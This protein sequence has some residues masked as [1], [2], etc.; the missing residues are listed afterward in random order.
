M[1]IETQPENASQPTLTPKR[2]V[3]LGHL[4]VSLPVVTIMG[5]VPLLGFALG[6]RNWAMIGFVLGF[7][8]AWLWWSIFVPRWREWARSQGADEERTQSLAE[9]SLLVWPKGSIFEKTEFR[10]RKKA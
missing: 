3:L 9:R 6:G 7:I 8:V 2:A 5:L 1:A 4:I 10:P